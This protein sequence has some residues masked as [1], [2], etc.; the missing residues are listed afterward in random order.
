MD[1]VADQSEASVYNLEKRVKPNG[2]PS[3]QG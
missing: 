2:I 1:D 3:A